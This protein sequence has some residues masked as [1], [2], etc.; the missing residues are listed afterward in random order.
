MLKKIIAL[1]VAAAFGTAAFAQA[2]AAPVETGKPEMNAPAPVAEKPA[3][4]PTQKAEK[5]AVKK[6]KAHPAKKKAK[7]VSGVESEPAGK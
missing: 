3:A 1:A 6:A 4:K 7:P 5:K 2:P